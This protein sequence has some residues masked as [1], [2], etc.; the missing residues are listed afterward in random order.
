MVTKAERERKNANAEFSR[1]MDQSVTHL[2]VGQGRDN[3][4][5]RLVGTAQWAHGLDG[6]CTCCPRRPAGDPSGRERAAAAVRPTAH[7]PRRVD[8]VDVPLLVDESRAAV[9]A[10]TRAAAQLAAEQH[11]RRD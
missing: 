10:Q 6:V 3:T 5:V 4:Q 7:V 11:G 8:V 1:M 9:I 2:R